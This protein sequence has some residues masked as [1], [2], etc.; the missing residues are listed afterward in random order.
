MLVDERF[1]R[2]VAFLYAE[3]PDDGRPDRLIKVP[4]GTAFF[5]AWLAKDAAYGVVYAAT[6]A[7]VVRQAHIDGYSTLYMRL[8]IKNGPPVERKV[9]FKS[10]YCH[11]DTDLA[12]AR[13]PVPQDNDFTW[14]T[15]NDL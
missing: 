14:V 11:D 12:I 10:W 6:A 8:R 1:R 2:C 13:L 9:H 4:V 3:V 15:R 5:V 7:H